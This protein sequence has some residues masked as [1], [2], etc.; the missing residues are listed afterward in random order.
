M[1]LSPRTAWIWTASGIAFPLA[2]TSLPSLATA[3][4]S[5]FERKQEIWSQLN[6]YSPTEGYHSKGSYGTNFGVGALAPSG[7]SGANDQTV[8]ADSKDQTD[9]PKPRLFLSRGTPW[10][11]DFGGSMT[12]LDGKKAMQAGAHIQ[13]TLFEGF[14]VPSIAL[15]GSHSEMR[16]YHEV[17]NIATDAI[18]LGVSYGLFRYLIVSAGVS[19]QWEKG[20]TQ[21]K[22]DFFSLTASDLP[23]WNVKRT[24]YSWGVNISP[25]TPFVQIGL[26]Q[27]F[28]TN[29]TQV[30]LAK[31]SFLL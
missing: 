23:V 7:F 21:A 26:E 13:W 12:M 18:E 31:L 15:R 11:V 14:S 19:E 10:P 2:L 20:E 8:T 3:Q 5:S 30:S 29:R 17:K 28:W 22:D 27:S 9:T 6:Y 16:N 1:E 4:I 24:V 25:F